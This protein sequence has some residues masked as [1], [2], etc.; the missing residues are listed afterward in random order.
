MYFK[1]LWLLFLFI[2]PCAAWAQQA[3]VNDR[4]VPGKP[5]LITMVRKNV[6]IQE[7]FSEL[8]DLEYFLAD[9][10]NLL[11]CRCDI[12]LVGVTVATF[13]KWLELHYPVTCSLSNRV[14]IIRL[15]RI[16]GFVY[17]SHNNPLPGSTITIK[18]TGAAF[19]TDNNG[20]F[21]WVVTEPVT[22]AFS[23]VNKQSVEKPSGIDTAMNV[24]LE[25]IVRPLAP[26]EVK[27][28]ADGYQQVPKNMAAGA[29]SAINM[30]M[31]NNNPAAN[32]IDR[33]AGQLPLF[34]GAPDPTHN[35]QPSAFRG[36]TTIY[37]NRAPLI[38]LDN[39]PYTGNTSLINP[40]DIDS[41]T[42]IKDAAAGAIWGTQAGN[43]VLVLTTKKGLH[44]PGKQLSF[45]EHFTTMGRPDNRYQQGP[46]ASQFVDFEKDIYMRSN[47]S[48]PSGFS[49]V[50]DILDRQYKGQ[51]TAYQASQL[52]EELRRRNTNAEI[53]KYLQQQGF[54]QQ[55]ALSLSTAA[56]GIRFYGSLG[57]DINRSNIKG[58]Q[59][60]RATSVVQ[61]FLEKKHFE[62]EFTGRFSRINSAN[63]AITLPST[64]PYLNLADEAG[65]PLAIAYQYPLQAIDQLPKDSFQDWHYYPLK[66]LVL[67]N[68]ATSERLYQAGTHLR[69]S[70]VRGLDAEF[71][72]QYTQSLY[73]RNDDHDRDSWFTSNLVNL[74]Y[75]KGSANPW[76][77]PIGSIRDSYHMDATGKNYRLQVNSAFSTHGFSFKGMAGVE[78]RQQ[79]IGITAQRFYGKGQEPGDINFTQV[80]NLSIPGL[81]PASIPYLDKQTDSAEHFRS[82]YFNGFISYRKKYILSAS[83]RKDQSNRFA[84]QANSRGIPLW[85]VGSSWHLSKEKFYSARLPGLTLRLT[86]G[87][88]GNINYTSVPFVTLQPEPANNGAPVY[89]VANPVGDPLSWERQFMFNAGIDFRLKAGALTGSI[90]YYRKH[91]DHV[92]QLQ[93][94]NPTSGVSLLKSHAGVIR[95][96]G[97]DLNLQMADIAL[98][99]GISWSLGLLCGFNKNQLNSP[100]ATRLFYANQA[101]WTPRQGDPVDALYAFPFAGLDPQNGTPWGWLGGRKSQDYTQILNDISSKATVYAGP[102]VPVFFGSLVQTFRY[103]HFTAAV[104]LLAKAGYYVRK[105][106]LNYYNM[107]YGQDG[108]T[109]D[110]N[111]RWQ[112][113]GDELVTDVPGF[114]SLPLDQY[115]DL[116]YQYSTA[117]IIRADHIRLQSVMLGRCWECKT[118][119]LKGLETNV[120]ITNLGILWRANKLG[121]DPDVQAG[122][123]PAARSYTLS[124]K[125]KF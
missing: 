7:I 57:A 20:R 13:M 71:F 70:F 80:Y 90:D 91:A 59:A 38:I 102:S 64:Q 121:I 2:G 119:R 101:N 8:T 45:T 21:E 63:N 96:Y 65:K 25:D 77:I 72:Y 58:N 105:R 74:Y 97:V 36:N 18:E 122:G 33:L 51:L 61:V 68:N 34:S 125:A 123:L 120:T 116:F 73:A 37:G 17:D 100:Q 83:M 3:V 117:N 41:I 60:N 24:L 10:A 114:Q 29:Y 28:F 52:L 12:T 9:G 16:Q 69:Y 42:L 81:A 113:P 110:F 47:Y 93:D 53:A 11:R 79:H 49:P 112:K 87:I 106:S 43:G 103:N 124:I 31:F 118:G 55:C 84:F 14:I 98:G 22:F 92:L 85:S 27:V 44:H 66:E 30:A 115:R 5:S 82:Y 62:A 78:Q 94:W 86:Y 75:Q 109:P 1:K 46:G 108:G 111:R 104:V 4:T 15:R 67:Y 54:Y 32:F 48:S 95:G 50:Q 39:F 6:T 56:P 89:T 99:P 88:V 19:M 26:A 23:Y 76:P 35:T 40:N 107:Y